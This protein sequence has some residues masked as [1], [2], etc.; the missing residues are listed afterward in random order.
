[1]TAS[2]VTPELEARIIRLRR[3]SGYSVNTIANKLGLSRKAVSGVLRED[4][5]PLEIR[6]S[7]KYA[8][9]QALGGCVPSSVMVIRPFATGY[10]SIPECKRCRVPMAGSLRRGWAA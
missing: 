2:R 7:R 1:M 9:C 6:T 5:S 10:F 4:L 3:N 8:K